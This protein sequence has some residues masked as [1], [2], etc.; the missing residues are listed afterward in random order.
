MG[1]FGSTT[2]K[3]LKNV[4]DGV[5]IAVTGAKSALKCE[6]VDLKE[7]EHNMIYP[8]V[9]TLNGVPLINM[10]PSY[11]PTCCGMLATGYGLD[12]IKCTE[13]TDISDSIN[14]GFNGI[15]K[16]IDTIRPLIGLLEDGIEG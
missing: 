4:P 5:I 14:S 8:K 16:F 15:E 1:L 7:D 9:M 10:H 13:L 6:L 2:I 12:N 3:I 11:C